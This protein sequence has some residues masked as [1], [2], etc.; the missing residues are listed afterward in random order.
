MSYLFKI[1]RYYFSSLTLIYIL[2]NVSINDV[3]AN[4]I[5]SEKPDHILSGY[6]INGSLWE[7]K[8]YC[9]NSATLGE[10]LYGSLTVNGT[11]QDAT[12]PNLLLKSKIGVLKYFG[13]KTNKFKIV[14]GWYFS[15]WPK[16]CSYLPK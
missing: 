10:S 16:T 1:N 11:K 7:L 4:S 3:S 5:I 13:E 9:Y 14:S 2:F 6:L 8:V 15:S 12:D